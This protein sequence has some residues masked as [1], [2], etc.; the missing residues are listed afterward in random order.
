MSKWILVSSIAILL[1]TGIAI[2]QVPTNPSVFE[3]CKA[4]YVDGSRD[5]SSYSND[6]EKARSYL[7]AVCNIDASSSQEFESK[8]NDLDTSGDTVYGLFKL[9]NKYNE[10]YGKFNAEFK[11]ACAKLTDESYLRSVVSRSSSKINKGLGEVFNTCVSTIADYAKKQNLAVFQSY[12]FQGEGGTRFSIHLTFASDRK[13]DQLKI[14]SIS[15]DFV[16]CRYAGNRLTLPFKLTSTVGAAEFNIDCDRPSNEQ[17]TFSVTADGMS[18]NK[19]EIPIWHDPIPELRSRT[20]ALGADLDRLRDDYRGELDKLKVS[21]NQE[22]KKFGDSVD[23]SK[24]APQIQ[25]VWP[26]HDGGGPYIKCT[27]GYHLYRLQ[28]QKDPDGTLR[29][30]GWCAAYPQLFIQ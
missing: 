5:L 13:S 8:A 26:A 27:P 20:D 29:M 14:T 2:A 28:A 19:V 24:L 30:G 15:P 12:N 22:L 1:P 3:I 10:N 21:I 16:S 6:T 9:N 7:N 25:T 18:T 17:I 23:E 4:V 11:L